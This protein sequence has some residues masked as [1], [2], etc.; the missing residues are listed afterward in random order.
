M[1][2]FPVSSSLLYQLEDYIK[3]LINADF[4]FSL[5][6]DEL[7]FMLSSIND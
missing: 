2:E 6:V 4:F 1:I 7:N 3:E 5:K